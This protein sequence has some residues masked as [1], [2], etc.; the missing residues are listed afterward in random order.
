[1]RGLQ[2][3]WTT[4]DIFSGSEQAILALIP[5]TAR[6]EGKV[7]PSDTRPL[8]LANT[9]YKLLMHMVNRRLVPFADQVCGP[10]QVG[11]L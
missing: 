5:K 9:N 7:I 3:A 4:G 8:D 6:T 11:F 2:Q 10:A 1:M